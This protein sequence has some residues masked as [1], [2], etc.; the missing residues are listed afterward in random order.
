DWLSAYVTSSVCSFL[1]LPRAPGAPLLP[2]TTLFR[3]GGVRGRPAVPGRAPP[4][5]ADAA[6]AVGGAPGGS[7]AAPGRL[8]HGAVRRGGAAGPARAVAAAGG[9]AAAG[10]HHPRARGGL[11]RAARRARPAPP[12]RR[13]CGY[14]HL[15]R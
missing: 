7:A 4:H 8:R 1:L 12:H 14:R 6:R 15:P 2:Y 9:R 3:S 5:V 13:L 11:G 10:R